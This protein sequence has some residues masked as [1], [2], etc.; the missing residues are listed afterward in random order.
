[1]AV[2]YRLDFDNITD[3]NIK[4]RLDILQDS[5]SGNVLPVKAGS[6]PVTISYDRTYDAYTPIIASNATVN[7]IVDDEVSY[8]DFSSGDYG[9]YEVILR[10]QDPND[11]NTYI[12]YWCGLVVKES[13][14]EHIAS[15]PYEVS[16]RA[17]DGLGRLSQD[18]VDELTSED[19]VSLL[20]LIQESLQQVP[21]PLG[22][23]TYTGIETSGSDVLTSEISRYAFY[24]GSDRPSHLDRLKDILTGANLTVFQSNANWYIINNSTYSSSISSNEENV[25][26]KQFN[27]QGI[28]QA[29]V[30]L[31]VLRDTTG[32][33]TADI[34]VAHNS[35]HTDLREPYGSIE[36]HIDNI[37]AKAL[38]QNPA[39]ALSGTGWTGSSL[40]F[41]TEIFN[42]AGRSITT[43]TTGTSD[44][45]TSSD[46]WFQSDSITQFNRAAPLEISF[47]Y[48]FNFDS[49]AVYDGEI[50]Y[51]I[52]LD[53][54]DDTGG[55]FGT[56]DKWVWDFNANLWHGLNL[57]SNR[58]RGEFHPDFIGRASSGDEGDWKSNS[59][60]IN[61]TLFQRGDNPRFYI[62]FLNPLALNSNEEVLNN[63]SGLMDTYLDNIRIAYKVNEDDQIFELVD[64]ALVNTK[65]YEYNTSISSLSSDILYNDL[66]SNEFNRVGVT[67]TLS[68]ERLNLQQKLNDFRD[69]AKYYRGS[70]INTSNTPFAMENKLLVNFPTKKRVN[71]SNNSKYKFL[72]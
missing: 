39:F 24:N 5:Y 52:V 72:T 25:T 58:G 70:L 15:F 33:D 61:S 53:V 69:F 44:E 47:D 16:F 9:E 66:N 51:R 59:L 13:Y 21:L 68:I 36:C 17:T 42:S 71:Y 46:V 63:G 23:R 45:A 32:S 41:N 1:M 60:D 7:L 49:N 22:L 64:D 37:Q 14:S 8:D 3:A 62:E 30:V 31:N 56:T 28:A 2:K 6:N 18:I 10:Y 20:T 4:W 67:E 27:S 54:D 50:R 26:F 38:N 48:Y 19:N 29:D 12:D 65:E 43:G 34:R 35:L 40:Q 55:V 11:T 57:D